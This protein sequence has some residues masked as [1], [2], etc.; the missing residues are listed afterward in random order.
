MVCKIIGLHVSICSLESANVLLKKPSILT[1][2]FTCAYDKSGT[3]ISWSR[4]WIGD[5]TYLP[6]WFKP[7]DGTFLGTIVVKCLVMS[8]IRFPFKHRPSFHLWYP[9]WSEILMCC[10]QD[11]AAMTDEEWRSLYN[12][13]LD[14]LGI[15]KESTFKPGLIRFLP[16]WLYFLAW[17]VQFLCVLWIMTSFLIRGLGSIITLMHG[18][19]VMSR[20]FWSFIELL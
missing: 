6:Q 12:V 10:W 11:V 5:G 9:S 17:G 18:L 15:L 16:F 14:W 7:Y 8:Q 2:K 4:P 13:W 20:K 1:N 3:S 19:L